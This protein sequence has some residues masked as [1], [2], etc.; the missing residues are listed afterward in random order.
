MVQIQ[1][2]AGA[3]PE[4]IANAMSLAGVADVR[5]AT[6]ADARVLIENRLMSIFDQETD[7]TSNLKGVER[8]NSLK[9]I[10]EKYGITPD[11]VKMVIGAAG[12]VEME[13]SDAA[14]DV[15]LEKTNNPKAIQHNVMVPHFG[16][17][18]S[19]EPNMSDEERAKKQ[20]EWLA[21]LLMT[22]QGGLLS[23]TVRWTE[24]VGGKGM[25][26]DSDVATGGADYVFL[27]P[28]QNATANEYGSNGNTFMYFDPRKLYKRLDFY[29]N[30]YDN[31]GKRKRN[32]DI[33]TAA[34][35]GAYELMFKHRVSF[36]ALQTFFVS[37]DAMA[38]SIINL[39]RSRGITDIGGRP[40]EDVIRAGKTVSV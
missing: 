15:I 30:Y 35:T 17:W 1:A 24:G 25:S 38:L 33:L 5:P 3:T 14:V 39:L 10:Q 26:S 8:E 19:N 4:Q 9:R 31:F 22:P 2:P 20:A 13:L 11:D 28:L 16:G 27:K 23:T 6:D 18:M 21:N 37:S 12:R 7:A 34:K 29:A 32:H 40:L 36:D